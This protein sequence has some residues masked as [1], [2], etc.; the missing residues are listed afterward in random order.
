MGVPVT[1]LRGSPD[2]GLQEAIR[3]IAARLA[4]QKQQV[5][6][7]VVDR[8]RQE[9]VDYR[10]PSD[11][12][13]L[14]DLFSATLERVD[15]LVASLQNGEPVPDEYL[16]RAREIAARRVHQG[17]PLESFL[18]AARLW[19]KVCWDTVLGVARTDSP[20]ER[21]AALEIAGV[22][23]EFADRLST[24]ATHAYPDE[25]CHRG[26][27]RRD[28]L[29]ALL[30]AKG[31]GNDVL[32]LARRLHLRLEENYI[33][34]LV[35]DEGVEL[36]EAREQPQGAGSRLDRMVEETRRNMRPA[37]GSLLMGMRNGDLVVLYP[38][39]TPADLDA[40]REDCK[41]L[42]AAL[43]SEVSIGMSGWHEGRASVGVAYAEA[44]DAVSIAARLGVQGRAVGLDEVLVDYLLD[45]S[46]AAQR[47]L[48]DVLRPL[49]AYDASRQAALV[50][51]LRAYLDTRCNVTKAA[52]FLFVNPNTVVYRLR[53]IKELTGRDPHN[54]DD[55]LVL[56]M[57]LRQN[58]RS[59]R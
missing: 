30:T 41:E 47:V 19:A 1:S 45:S 40:V 57:A 34:V 4:S 11:R 14:E 38:V 37:G 5:A 17:V 21:E 13:L 43:G 6:Q 3:A 59:G 50:A 39:S 7:R 24:A 23:A 53:R 15:A 51:T 29:D 31:T 44:K 55:R 16:E 26:L 56:S 54:A 22:V 48:D 9:I 58:A 28:L 52:A 12:H 27:L 18:H 35:R 2:A 32:R 10:A 36:E 33:V 42:A 25:I 46:V 8:S 49:V 20:N